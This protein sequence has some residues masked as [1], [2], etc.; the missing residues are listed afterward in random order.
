MFNFD[1]Q[2]FGGLFGGGGGGETQV[3]EK[4]VVQQTAPAAISSSVQQESATDSEKADRK[5]KFGESVRGR[6]STI[7]GAGTT[8][9]ALT[10]AGS[11]AKT[12]LG[13]Q[14]K[15]KTIGGA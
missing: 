15:K 9:G 12:L 14:P 10:A 13:E 3:I 11:I 8:Q 6:R 5:K 2:L 4:P 7:T 1:L